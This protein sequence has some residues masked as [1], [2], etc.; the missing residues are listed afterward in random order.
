M[1]YVKRDLSARQSIALGSL[2]DARRQPLSWAIPYRAVAPLAMAC[3]AVIIVAMSM[4][5]GAVYHLE[6]IGAPGDLAQFAGFA[7]IVAALF[8][9]IG[10]NRDIYELS[11]VL[12]FKSQIWK[13]SI[14]W[15]AVFLS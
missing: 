9:A 10:K 4:I 6:T 14:I 13:I 7:A 11:E 1:N 15:G 5:S 3:D 2:K 8:V 12:N